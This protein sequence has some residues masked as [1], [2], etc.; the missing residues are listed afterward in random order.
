MADVTRTVG[1]AGDSSTV[2]SA[3]TWMQSGANYTMGTDDIGII[4]II[5]DAEFTESSVCDFSGFTGTASATSYVRLE[6]TVQGDGTYAGG[7]RIKRTAGG[8]VISIG[9]N[10]THIKGV[11]IHQG[12]GTSSD[13]GIRVTSGVTSALIEKCYIKTN[14]NGGS[15]TGSQDCIYTGNWAV[16]NL[17]IFDCVCTNGGTSSRAGIHL[18][19]YNG[20]ATQD[21]HIEHCA[22]NDSGGTAGIHAEEDTGNSTNT[23][24]WNCIG[25]GS[26]LNYFMDGAG[27]GTYQGQGNLGEHV[28]ACTNYLGT[29]ENQNNATVSVTD[30]AATE[31]LVTDLTAD[32]QDYQI[33]DGASSGDNALANAVAPTSSTRDSRIDITVDIAGNPRP[34]T[35]TDRASGAFEPVSAASGTG[36][37]I[38][39]LHR[40]QL[41]HMLNR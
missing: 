20:S 10:Y 41:R 19:N 13:E 34:A 37:I 33:I 15:G 3:I 40:N 9:E 30:E 6:S 36:P 22:V 28:S 16:T 5:D 29:T 31:V 4:Q 35:F 38:S 8:H 17:N 14:Y 23:D 2:N 32:A 7:S 18:Q 12:G 1:A 26:G 21:V 11:G 25:F 24:V 27:S 39:M